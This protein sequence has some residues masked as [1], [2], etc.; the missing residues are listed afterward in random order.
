MLAAMPW[1]LAPDLY[2]ADATTSYDRSKAKA[3]AIHAPPPD[4]PLA[5]RQ[6]RLTGAGRFK[7]AIDRKTGTVLSV[8]TVK[9]TG[10][11]VLDRAA[12]T[13]FRKWR[14]KP[15]TSSTVYMP[16]SFSTQTGR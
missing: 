9:S 2:A 10:H 13:A 7:L 1:L 6:R 11:A 5:A 15:G 16:I 3:V 4:Y 8:A 14:F 12:A